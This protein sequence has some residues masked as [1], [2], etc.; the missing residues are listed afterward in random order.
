MPAK[1]A[2]NACFFDELAQSPK[3]LLSRRNWYRQMNRR[4]WW[5]T[6]RAA[7]TW[8]KKVSRI[9]DGLR[10]EPVRYGAVVA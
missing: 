8:P 2:E 3:R 6:L 4:L 5:H 7:E 10:E 1:M 9:A